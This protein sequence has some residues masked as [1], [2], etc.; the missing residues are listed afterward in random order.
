M[1]DMNKNDWSSLIDEAQQITEAWGVKGYFYF[2]YSS[3][4]YVSQCV[5]GY[6]KKHSWLLEMEDGDEALSDLYIITRTIDRVVSADFGSQ[7]LVSIPSCGE[8]SDWFLGD[9]ILPNT[10]AKELFKIQFRGQFKQVHPE[11]TEKKISDFNAI[12]LED[13]PFPSLRHVLTEFKRRC[14]DSFWGHRGSYNF[15]FKTMCMVYLYMAFMSCP[16]ERFLREGLLNRKLSK[17]IEEY[18]RLVLAGENEKPFD[19]YIRAI[20][21]SDPVVKC[22]TEILSLEDRIMSLRNECASL[23]GKIEETKKK[24]RMEIRAERYSATKAAYENI[25][26]ECQKVC[27]YDLSIYKPEKDVFIFKYGV[28]VVYGKTFNL[29]EL[30]HREQVSETA[31]KLVFQ[32]DSVT[33]ECRTKENCEEFNTILSMSSESIR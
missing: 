14:D 17:Y 6:I 18:Y 9:G 28:L 27:S 20:E 10:E 25:F 16:M 33:I 19:D 23:E 21:S 30:E 5:F 31:V 32:S 12:I 26:G 7:R 11:E 13:I 4:Q 22:E 24:T 8:W 3:F 15:V 2:R 1:V 29:G